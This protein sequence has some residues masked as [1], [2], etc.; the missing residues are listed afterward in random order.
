[1]D[2][3][4]FLLGAIQEAIAHNGHLQYTFRFRFKTRFLDGLISL[5]HGEAL[6]TSPHMQ[7]RAAASGC[8]RV[9][10]SV[11]SHCLIIVS[12]LHIVITSLL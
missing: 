12:K 11:F 10:N 9:G 4:P 6:A 5:H 3:D 7:F 1:V 8:N 2:T